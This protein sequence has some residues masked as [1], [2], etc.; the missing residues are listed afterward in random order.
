MTEYA[1]QPGR[2]EIPIESSEQAAQM[3]ARIDAWKALPPEQRTVAME[4]IIAAEE[5][6]LAAWSTTTVPEE[7]A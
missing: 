6:L 4:E 7:E 5:A 3:Q 2:I 1:D